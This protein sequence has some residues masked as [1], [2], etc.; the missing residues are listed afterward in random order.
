MPIT[1]TCACSQK[2]AV[3]NE[4]AGQLHLCAACG[5]AMSIP[6]MGILKRP[7]EKAQQ[8][9][10]P[11]RPIVPILAASGLFLLIGMI[12]V[13][14]WALSNAAAT[15]PSPVAQMKPMEAEIRKQP[16][17]VERPPAEPDP[18]PV[19]QPALP[20][21][22]D[23]KPVLART[24]PAAPIIEPTLPPK[25]TAVVPEKKPANLLEPL[26][27]IWK[28]KEADT[29]YQELIV[30]QRPTFKV[31]GLPIESLLQY[32]VVSRF[33]VQKRNDDGSLVVQQKI[34][35]AKLLQADDLSK[36]TIMGAVAQMPGTIYT[37]QLS[38]K[39]DVTQFQAGADIKVQPVAGGQGMQMASL[40]DRDGWKE[41]VQAT[42]FQMEQP[43]KANARWAKPMTHAWGALGS[44]SGKVNYAYAGPQDKLHKITYTLQLKH[45]AK[46]GGQIGGMAINGANF[47]AQEAAGVLLFDAERGKVVAAEERF[48]V[49]GVVNA[50]LLGQNTLI[51]ISEDQHFLIRIH[52]KSRSERV[53]PGRCLRKGCE[54]VDRINSE[55]RSRAP[56]PDRGRPGAGPVAASSR[57]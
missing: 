39:M 38:P 41:L 48:R 52:D 12:G 5:K 50:N 31:Q 16:A 57:R 53:I 28:L 13:V 8:P 45:Q 2:L 56:A 34:E 51:E 43:L 32:R 4:L 20:E 23:P 25:A 10:T 55:T 40:L 46:K 30:T 11:H 27:L 49:K 47:Q 7:K 37:L 19:L 21:K 36:A 35:S 42:F 9:S 44:W 29:F 54:S 33:D 18:P 3:A 26:R 15:P 24:P 22:A 1:L 17:P 14:A 6:A